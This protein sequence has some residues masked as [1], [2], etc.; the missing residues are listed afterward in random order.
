MLQRLNSSQLV[1]RHVT[2]LHP[3]L[4]DRPVGVQIVIISEFG[5]INGNLAHVLTL[6]GFH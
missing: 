1:S 3:T 5:R 4:P 2:T 6:V